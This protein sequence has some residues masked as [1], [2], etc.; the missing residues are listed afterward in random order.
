MSRIKIKGT[1]TKAST[2]PR[3]VEPSSGRPSN[4]NSDNAP[5]KACAGSINI[6]NDKTIQTTMNKESIYFSGLFPDVERDFIDNEQFLSQKNSLG[7][8]KADG[9]VQNHHETTQIDQ[10]SSAR[11][12]PVPAVAILKE[13]ILSPEHFDFPYPTAAEKRILMKKTGFSSKQ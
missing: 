3:S 11:S 12:L 13:W 2:N 8:N 5:S 4:M 7:H 10:S 1:K 9:E 6:N